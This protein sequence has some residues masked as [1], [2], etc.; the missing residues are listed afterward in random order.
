MNIVF[1]R[2]R[3]LYKH[4]WVQLLSVI[5]VLLMLVSAFVLPWL[6]AHA[7]SG[8]TSSAHASNH[9]LDSTGWPSTFLGD[10]GRSNFNGAETVINPSTA[11]TLHPIWEQTNCCLAPTTT[12]PVVANGLLYWGSW[13]GNEH[14]TPFNGGKD[15]WKR[16][17]G[18]NNHANLSCYPPK[19]G[20]ASTGTVATITINGQPTSVLF[21]GGGNA[22]LFALDAMTGAIIWSAPLGAL[23]SHFLW[24]SPAVYNG[25]VYIGMSS[26][27][28]CPLVQAKF[29]QLDAATGKVLKAFSLV[30]KGCVG[31]SVWGSPTIDEQT[32]MIYFA[33]GNGGACSQ[34]E[35]Y[36]ISLV[37]L[38]ASDL[39]FVASWQVPNQGGDSDFG[40]TP[41][42]F[43]ATI[44]GTQRNMIGLINKNG[45][46]YA[47]D[48]TNI[49]AGPLWQDQLAAPK[50]FGGSGVDISSS[51]WDGTTLYAAANV[52]T[53]NGTSCK[54]SVSAINPADGSFLWQVCLQTGPQWAPVMAVPGLVIV[55]SG[56]TLYVFDSS[57][58]NTL[59][60]YT[61]SRPG[62]Y[63]G[64]SVSISGGVLY[65]G[66]FH[67]NLYAFAPSGSAHT[68]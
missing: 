19:A 7:D 1:D 16:F 17:L 6:N 27:G 50:H 4:R 63:F 24:G 46:Y 8:A 31:A 42:L 28:D 33:T 41:T 49:A 25:S 58:G 9:P 3:Q 37:E 23:P 11:P 2:I 62:A 40:S 34:K 48:R 38:Q 68:R 10:N 65:A 53:I 55:G 35:P 47:L 44:N 67:G 39:S 15:V 51:A 61:A 57:N 32:G 29:F 36:A 45:A 13:S 30:P 21:V 20:V 18:L 12:Q 60:S 64:G 52:T 54:S 66:D 26:F 56:P 5:S 14:A 59:Y 22:N 43:Q